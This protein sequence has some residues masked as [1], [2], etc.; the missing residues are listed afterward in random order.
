MSSDM[1]NKR[2]LCADCLKCGID[3]PT[4]LL[5]AGSAVH[6]DGSEPAPNCAW[7]CQG[8]LMLRLSQ[9]TE[10]VYFTTDPDELTS[11]YTDFA[12]LSDLCRAEGGYYPTFLTQKAPTEV[13]RQELTFLADLY[14]AAQSERGDPRRAFRS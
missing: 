2:H 6:G 3:T 5:V 12:S 9:G 13:R 4:Y 11:K 8:H 1:L 7:L 10:L 14:D